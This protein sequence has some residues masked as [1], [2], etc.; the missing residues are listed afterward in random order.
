MAANNVNLMDN[1]QSFGTILLNFSLSARAKDRL[2]EDYPTANDL[3]ASN[4][5]QI[6]SVVTNQNKMYRSHAT[7]N[8]RCYINTSQLNRILAFYRWTTFAIKDAHAEYDVASVAAFDL[9]WINSIVD[10]YNIK[11]PEV[12]PQSTTFSVTIPVFNGTNWHDVK[13]KL[14]ALLNTRTGNSGIPLTYLVRDVAMSWEDT[15]HMVNLQER[16]IFS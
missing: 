9:N 12:T 13:A 16:R 8:Q 6:K 3:M 11:D 10:K 7:A 2:T 15:E 4:V 5:A 14:I 1:I